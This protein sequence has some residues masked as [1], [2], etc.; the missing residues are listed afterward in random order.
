MT[1]YELIKQAVQNKQS[2]SFDY[3]NYSRKMSPH[4]IGRSK[5]GEEQTLCYQNGGMTSSGI[6]TP[7]SNNNWRCVKIAN[8]RNLT[9]NNDRFQTAN[10][11]TKSQ[12]CV[13][14]IDAE[15]NY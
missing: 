4:V 12:S 5:E 6:I 14:V 11:H 2:I 8:I 15:I 10:N 7:N 3:N 1:N 13:H 9:V